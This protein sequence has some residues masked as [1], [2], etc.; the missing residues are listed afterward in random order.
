M[1]SSTQPSVDLALTLGR[2][3]ATAAGNDPGS[4]SSVWVGQLLASALVAALV[5]GLIGVY[6][7]VR[8]GRLEERAR[9]RTALAE[10][11]QACSEYKEFPYAIRRRRADEPGA[12]RVRLSEELRAVQAR[13]TYH[14]AW[15]RSE[16]AHVGNAYTEL[17]TQVRKVAG[18]GM[19]DAWQG[20]ALDS[21]PGMNISRDQ[22]D[23]STLQ[24][25]EDDYVM[26]V[27]EHV[28]RIGSMWRLR[29]CGCK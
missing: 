9:V 7:A 8:A 16:C 22:L 19:K 28:R 26:A 11:F 1:M 18:T 21:D 17:V 3:C 6:L 13:L 29:G 4:E 23:L 10:A 5:S 12:E 14:T 27:G 20:P 25:V 24:S 2:A 15:T